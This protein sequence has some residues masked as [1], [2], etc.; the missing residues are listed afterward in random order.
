MKKQNT[1]LEPLKAILRI[2]SVSTET[3][4][5]PEMKRAREF[6]VKKFKVLGF[7]TKILKGKRHDAVF[8]ERIVDLKRQ[9]ALI[10][11]HYDVQP[12]EPIDEW[13]SNPFEPAVKNGKIYA[14]G[15]TDNKGQFMAHLMAISDIIAKNGKGT[16]NFKF[17]IEGEEEI[18]SISIESLAK[19]YAKS[20]FRADFIVVSDSE[21]YEAEQP[22]IDVGLRGLTYAEIFLRSAKNDVH[23]GQFGNIAPNPAIELARIIAKLKSEDGRV[24][25]PGFYDDFKPF[26]KN[27]LKDFNDL[28]V[29]GQKL[30]D[31]GGM[32]YIDRFDKSFS[33][34]ERRWAIP[35]LDVNGITSGYQGEGSKTIIPATAS[36]KVSM[37]LVPNQNP[38][39][40]FKLFEKFVKRHTP[41]RMEIKVVYH[42]GALPYK[43]PAYSPLFGLMK[44]CLKEVYKKD[45]VYSGVGGSIGF[46][47]TVANT[48]KVPCLMVGFGLPDENLHAPNEHFGIK[49]YFRGIETMTMFYASLWKKGDLVRGKT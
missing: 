18:G 45:A 41:P 35:T 13:N 33:L 21:M 29:T 17:L 48:L 20:L 37:R 22:T 24:L 2:K 27:E 11:G 32:F 36:A 14:R 40:I 23:S 9:T 30:K 46:V 31:E 6:L 25:I 16:I 39:K 12:A 44:E 15:A 42:S 10:Y 5:K 38:L 1:Y 8:A 34:N 26:S 7:T 19:K 4:Y 49:N 43:A 3:M 47:P 28:K